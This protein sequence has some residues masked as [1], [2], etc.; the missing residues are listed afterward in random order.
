MKVMSLLRP[1]GSFKKV[2]YLLCPKGSFKKTENKQRSVDFKSI[3]HC[4][5]HSN[6]VSDFSSSLF[7]MWLPHSSIL[8][9]FLSSICMGE[10]VLSYCKF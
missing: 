3:P 5:W 9:V 7:C 4:G 10:G 2:M 1:K 6:M 8:R